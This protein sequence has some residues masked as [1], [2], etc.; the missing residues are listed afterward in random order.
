MLVPDWIFI[1]YASHLSFPLNSN[2]YPQM[3]HKFIMME[4]EAGLL[5][6]FGR[7]L[8]ITLSPS[9]KV[10]V[11]LATSKDVVDTLL[12]QQPT[13]HLTP[14]P[15]IQKHA[16]NI[17]TMYRTAISRPVNKCIY[18]YIQF[19]I[20]RTNEKEGNRNYR[21]GDLTKDV[22]TW[23]STYIKTLG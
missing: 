19:C 18:K 22:S 8:H 15:F 11:T 4:I 10:V 2:S 23:S 14:V 7:G 20:Y 16:Q 21:N 5:A 3:K 12:I 1:R 13:A 9:K 6:L 17:F